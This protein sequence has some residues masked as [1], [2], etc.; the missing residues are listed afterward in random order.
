MSPFIIEHVKEAL[1]PMFNCSVFVEN[2]LTFGGTEI[3]VNL[4][5]T[6]EHTFY[7]KID[8]QSSFEGLVKKR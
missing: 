6:V 3:V 5:F 7:R 8:T 4:K 2:G 1:S